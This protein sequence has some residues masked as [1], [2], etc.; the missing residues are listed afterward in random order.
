MHTH[1]ICITSV[2]LTLRAVR[3]GESEVTGGPVGGTAAPVASVFGCAAPSL[4]SSGASVG[5]PGT[6][7]LFS[8]VPVAASGVLRLFS[9][10]R[11]R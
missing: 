11:S 8:V 9:I 2:A 10:R 1:S 6:A 3:V 7:A 5:A 4:V